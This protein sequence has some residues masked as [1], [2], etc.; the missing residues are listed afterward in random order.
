MYLSRYVN[1]NASILGIGVQN[2]EHL[3]ILKKYLK[4][5]KIYGIDIDQNV[6][7]MD[8]GKNIKTFCF[9]ATKE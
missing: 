9:D 1:K 7:K 8:L 2:G 5:A 3:Q 6:C 4:N